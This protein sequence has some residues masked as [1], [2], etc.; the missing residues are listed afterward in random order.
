MSQYQGKRTAPDLARREI[1]LIHVARS[2]LAIDDDTYRT[3]LHDR[4]GVAS[5]KDMDWKQRKLLLDHF[6]TCGFKVKSTGKATGAVKAKPSR[7]LAADPESRKIRSLWILLHEL[8]A[9]RNP[10][11]AALAMYVKRLAKVDALQWVN[12][13]QAK[14][15]IETL[16]KWA[17]RFLPAKVEAMAKQCTE[18]IQSGVLKLPEDRLN[19]LHGVIGAAQ[20]YGTFDPMQDAYQVLTKALN[21]GRNG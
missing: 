10:S 4:Y 5:S 14:T 18:V 16:K 20:R 15:L 19:E 11:E 17:M 2:Q 12:G 9:V 21:E 8:G 13:D 6:K 1:Q 3:L 7:A